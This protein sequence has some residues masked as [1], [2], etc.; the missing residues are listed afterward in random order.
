VQAHG[1]PNAEQRCNVLKALL[2]PV[3]TRP[4]RTNPELILNVVRL[5]KDLRKIR[6]LTI[7]VPRGGPSRSRR[8]VSRVVT[9]ATH[10]CESRALVATLDEDAAPG[11][12]NK[13][14]E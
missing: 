1:R 6:I 5:A 8:P 14:I 2:R 10:A 13:S 9:I 3:S 12:G 11:G 4:A 7:G